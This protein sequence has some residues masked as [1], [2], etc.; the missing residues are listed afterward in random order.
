MKIENTTALV[1]GA[2]RGL[3]KA[4]VDALAE[5]GATVYAAARSDRGTERPNI[6]PVT[7]DVTEPGAVADV[8]ARLSEVTL[9]VNNAGVLVRGGPISA[10]DLAG[11]RAEMEVNY[12]GSLAM[13]RAFAPVIERNGGGAI[14]NVAS[15]L[16]HVP[17]PGAGT[18]SASKA[19]ALSMTQ[20]MR[21]ELAPRGIRV[22]G[23][24][25]A[26]V[27]T[28]M[29]AGHSGIKLSP[30]AVAADLLDALRGDTEDIYPG[31]ARELVQA[32]Y[33][34][35]KGYERQLAN[36]PAPSHATRQAAAQ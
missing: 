17:I 8:A 30:E 6:V 34:D 27:D 1:T 20:A 18:Y 2:N 5:A 12:F 9:L 33:V 25:P 29:A 36:I 28:D 14:V 21:A 3:G 13:A 22:I 7:L 31:R 10:P 26:F 16:A 35:P 4:I 24:L 23:L 15:I 11:A 32:F 19:A